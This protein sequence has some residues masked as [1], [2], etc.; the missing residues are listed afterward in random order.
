MTAAEFLT[1]ASAQTRGRYE[2]VRG[3]VVLLPPE[4]A[5]HCL[6]KEAV[7]RALGDAVK[8]A[9]L[10]YFVFGSGMAV[11]VDDEHV[12]DPDGS[13]QSKAS[14]DLDSV[15]LD[16]PLIVVEVAWPTERGDTDDKLVEYFSVP[17]INHFLIVSPTRKAVVH[18]VRGQ[19][20]NIL[21]R[22]MTD[23]EIDLSPPGITVPVAE[24]LPD[25][26]ESA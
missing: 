4:R 22:I 14:T 25:F 3:E 5:G 19:G 2:L 6:T 20:G 21:T 7:Y 23:G 15:T 18:H 24:L 12:R 10:P 11:V 9:R 13:V 17:G 8:R 16:A 26:G 1:W